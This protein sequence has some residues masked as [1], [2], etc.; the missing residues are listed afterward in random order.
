[1]AQLVGARPLNHKVAGSTP[2]RDGGLRPLQLTT[3]TGPGA[4]LCP[5]QLRLKGQQLEAERHPPQLRL[6][7]QQLDLEKSPGSTHCSPI[8]SYSPSPI[9]SFKNKN[10]NCLLTASH[11]AHHGDAKKKTQPQLQGAP[12]SSGRSSSS[13]VSKCTI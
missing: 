3:A 10:I 6:K 1:M 8:K 13:R 12:Q 7:G 2:A 11:N 5:P 4:E 9:K